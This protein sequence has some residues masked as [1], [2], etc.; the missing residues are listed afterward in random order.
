MAAGRAQPRAPAPAYPP[1]IDR[2]PHHQRAARNQPPAHALQGPALQ[3]GIAVR[4]D[5]V[6]A[7]DEEGPSLK[8]TGKARIGVQ[9][10]DVTKDLAER[11]G[12]E[13]TAGALVT[14]VGD[15]TP[16]ERAGIER[17]NVILEV[18]RQPVE[19]A[20]AFTKAVRATEPGKNV[21]LLVRSGRGTRYVAVKPEAGK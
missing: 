13:D 20:A 4:E 8:E 15:G 12:L 18:N 19:S 5:E 1:A 14:E 10:Q 7:E 11:L 21:L 9:V 16:A 17:G 3:G 2:A 6:A